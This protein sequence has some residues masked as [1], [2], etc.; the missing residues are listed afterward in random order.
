MLI[1]KKKRQ[2][3]HFSIISLC[4]H[5][6]VKTYEENRLP[7]NSFEVARINCSE[8]TFELQNAFDQIMYMYGKE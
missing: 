3:N 8:V 7:V 5:E 6:Q 2:Q 1:K 4:Q